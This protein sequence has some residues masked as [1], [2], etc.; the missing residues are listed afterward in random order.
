MTGTTFF[1]F[2]GY[3]LFS[4]PRFFLQLRNGW[5]C[6]VERVLPHTKSAN[7]ACKTLLMDQWGPKSVELAH[8]MNKLTHSKTLCILLDYI[9]IYYQMIHGPYNMKSI[10]LLQDNAEHVYVTIKS[11]WYKQRWRIPLSRKLDLPISIL[12][13]VS[14]E[15]H[16]LNFV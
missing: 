15:P 5:T 2:P 8:V 14:S 16:L 3:C 13:N 6:Q 1:I 12:K 10:S 11:M 4:Q 9:Y 7:T